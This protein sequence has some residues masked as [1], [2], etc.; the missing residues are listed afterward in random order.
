[1]TK[2]IRLD[3]HIHYTPPT[4]AADMAQFGAQEPYWELLLA[5]EPSLQGWA[6]A[7]R[8]VADMDRAGLDRVLIQGEYRQRHETSVIRN[9]QALELVNRWPDRIMAFAMIQP[10]AGRKAL[11]ELERCRAG[12]LCGV[13]ELNPY[14]Q[15]YSLDDPDFL[16]VV[17]YAIHHN[18]P[19]ALHVSEEVGPYYP[20][21]ST[22]PL[23]HYYELARRYP[24][25]KLILA[26]WGGGLLFYEIM[27]RVRRELGQV[28]YDTAASPLLYPTARIFTVALQ[29]VDH[30]KILYG[31]D[32]PLRLYPRRQ[33]EPDFAPF[34]AEIDGLGLAEEIY[35]DIM[36][37]N[38]A[39]LL[40]LEENETASP[41]AVLKPAPVPSP[42]IQGFM[43]VP[44]VA[45][46]WPETQA[47]F[48]KFHIPWRDTPV[49]AWEPIIQAAAAQGWGA[50][51]QQRLL[52]ALNEAIQ[53]EA[54]QE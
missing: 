15:G 51:D 20:G 42:G 29:A 17:E 23:R 30:R 49:P 37:R 18:L 45:T 48:E 28:W 5:G 22:T 26:H 14:A 24:D 35:N 21:K 3:A 33:Q 38:A 36:G 40:G 4:L 27:P 43:A 32:Y 6:S 50:L 44:L 8:M 13:G 9:D 7:E 10:K 47:I 12:G 41:T 25:L 34:I 19:L 46:T 53:G 54:S 52:E 31:S 1:M 2:T 16:R 39:R 11:E